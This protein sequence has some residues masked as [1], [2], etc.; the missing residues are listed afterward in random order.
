MAERPIV[1]PPCRRQEHRH[2]GH[3]PRIFAAECLR[4]SDETDN[5]GHR[6]LMIRIAKTWVHTPPRWIAMLRLAT[7]YC[8]TCVGSST[9]S[10][11][12]RA[13]YLVCGVSAVITL[14]ALATMVIVYW[15]M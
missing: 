8:R 6:D 2:A 7:R 1:L 10:I 14:S 15:R 4:W 3:S 9:R 13:I 12:D 11:S 5:A